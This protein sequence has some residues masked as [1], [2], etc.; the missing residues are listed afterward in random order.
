MNG[1]GEISAVN[2]KSP[3]SVVVTS[4][5]IV[6]GTA[7][8]SVVKVVRI[9][10][11]KKDSAT[12]VVCGKGEISAVNVE[13]ISFVVAGTGASVGMISDEK[14]VVKSKSVV[15][16]A[17]TGANVGTRSD[18]GKGEISAVNVDRKSSVVA[19][20]GARVGGISLDSIG[21]GTN[22]GAIKV[23]SAVWD[24]N[25]ISVVSAGTG[26]SV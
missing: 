10:V 16:V 24:S 23:G 13:R 26:A 15:S 3:A 4:S 22:V 21:V 8:I 6:V 25:G 5:T 1:N 20:T 12:S 18:V 17:G 2:V 9:T 14:I 11:V 7:E 19:G